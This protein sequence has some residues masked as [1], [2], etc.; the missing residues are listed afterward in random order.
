MLPKNNRLIRENDF[1]AVYRAGKGRS[2][3]FLMIK[4]RPNGLGQTR[5]GLV[6]SVKIDKRAVVRNRIRRQLSE[7][8]RRDLKEILPA[9]DVV[10]VAK[11][12]ISGKSFKEIQ[13]EL[14]GLLEAN[15]LLVR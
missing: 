6:V 7:S 2:T 13:K 4:I 12:D 8:V 10:L 1:K 3:D 15:R 5:F 11:K 14:H 9:F